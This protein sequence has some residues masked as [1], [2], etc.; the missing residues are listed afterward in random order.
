MLLRSKIEDDIAYGLGGRAAEEIVFGE[1]STGA[2]SD[3]EKI[4]KMARAMVTR[5]GM[6]DSLGPLTYG[7][8]EELVFLGKEIGEQRDYSEAVAH[9][10][11]EEVRQIIMRAYDRAKTVIEEHREQMDRIV[12]YLMER[13]TLSATE[14]T[15]AFDGRTMPKRAEKPATS[16][17]TETAEPPVLKTAPVAA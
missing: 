4:T 1:A 15:A 16:P 6:N 17:A 8:K 3:L 13:E 9:Q 12:N 14:F 7:R 10:I 5:F 11:D 2:S